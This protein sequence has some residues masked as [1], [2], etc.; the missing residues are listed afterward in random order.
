MKKS[1]Q[2]M[3]VGSGVVIGALI[4]VMRTRRGK[5]KWNM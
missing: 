2:V 3:V 1:F 5:K 4:L